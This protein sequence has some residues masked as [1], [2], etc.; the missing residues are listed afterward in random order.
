MK[1]VN[2]KGEWKRAVARPGRP[3]GSKVRK[4]RQP[5]KPSIADPQEQDLDGLAV[6][7]GDFA[8]DDD[9]EAIF[10]PEPPQIPLAGLRP[11]PQPPEQTPPDPKVSDEPRPS[12]RQQGMGRWFFGVALCL[13]GTGYITYLA[14]SDALR[15]GDGNTQPFA[16][17]RA[18]GEPPPAVFKGETIHKLP[19]SSAAVAPSPAAA[20]PLPLPVELRQM[21]AAGE[22]ADPEPAPREAAQIPAAVIP[23][24]GCPS[25]GCRGARAGGS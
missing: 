15:P 9:A 24:G 20:F 5:E 1:G 4:A 10:A 3:S 2:P 7:A 12:P 16:E 18:A 22:S 19:Q 21:P 23:S 6:P 8:E 13:L 17:S 25:G 14:M 11:T